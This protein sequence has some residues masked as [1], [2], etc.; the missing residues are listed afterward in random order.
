MTLVPKSMHM[1]RLQLV[2]KYESLLFPYMANWFLKRRKPYGKTGRGGIRDH[3]QAASFSIKKEQFKVKSFYVPSMQMLHSW[4]YF[5]K[6][7]ICNEVV[8]L[9]F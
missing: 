3:H 2:T 8:A 7:T 4:F 1:Q 6:Q 9:S 5:L